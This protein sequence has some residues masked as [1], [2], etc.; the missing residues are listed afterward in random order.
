MYMEDA[1]FQLLLSLGFNPKH[2]GFQYV[3]DA[4]LIYIKNGRASFGDIYRQIAV[5]YGKNTQTVMKCMKNAIDGAL[6][7]R[8][9]DEMLFMQNECSGSVSCSRFIAYFGDKCK[10]FS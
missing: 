3:A 5:R 6:L 7:R 2:N 8:F 4:L 10:G 1:I 9:C